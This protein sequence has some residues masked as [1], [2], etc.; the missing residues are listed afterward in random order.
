MSASPKIGI[1][2]PEATRQT[3]IDKAAEQGVSLS[4]VVRLL[5]DAWIHEPGRSSGGGHA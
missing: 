3:A 5:I 2:L 1:R 4:H